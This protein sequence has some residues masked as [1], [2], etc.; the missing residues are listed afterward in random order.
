MINHQDHRE[1]S[2]TTQRERGWKRALIYRFSPALLIESNLFYFISP[3]PLFC[4]L[5][6]RPRTNRE[7]FVLRAGG[8]GSVCDRR[9][10]F[11]GSRSAQHAQRPVSRK[12]WPLLENG[13]HQWHAAAQVHP[14][15]Q[16]HRWVLP[17]AGRVAQHR[18]YGSLGTL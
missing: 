18:R 2:A 11:Y 16:L 9:G 3:P 4:P 12:S 17:T 6:F 14:P 10:L 13:H 7:R 5:S 8:E 1:N 15:R